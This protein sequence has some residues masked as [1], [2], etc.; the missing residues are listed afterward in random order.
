MINILVTAV[1]SELSFS[2]IKAIKLI[3]YPCRLVGC[4]IYPEVVGKYWCSNFYIVPPA[5]N[6]RQYIE[7]LKEIIT[8]H[9]IHV[10]VPT[11]DAEIL[12][13]SKYKSY[14]KEILNCEILVNDHAEIKIYFD[15]WQAY[16]YYIK[17][18]IPTP[19]TILLDKL[20]GLSKKLHCM[21]YPLILKPRAGGGSRSIYQIN[22]FEDI[23]KYLPFTPGALIQEYLF[24]DE[25]EYTAGTYRNLEG[26]ILVIVMKRALKF[27]M[28][29]SA[30]II[31]DKRLENFCR[32]V[33]LKTKL[34]GSNNIQFRVTN[35]GPKILE[36][37]PRFSG[38]AGIRA[39]FGFNDVKMWIE[40]IKLQKIAQQPEIKRGFVMRYMQE[41]YHFNL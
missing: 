7:S 1:G 26:D 32:E 8:V 23:I 19:K 41:Q 5:L 21:T 16:Q 2:I 17:N 6:D 30:E 15:K 36:I 24:P 33:I 3:D 27:G 18:K 11:T 12:L 10:I 40:E 31:L 9:K 20:D 38:S 35:S 4:D 13:L 29:N 14:F 25:A 22:S 39:N 34:I 28:T 37:N